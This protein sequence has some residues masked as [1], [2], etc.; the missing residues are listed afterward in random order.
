VTVGYPFL[1]SVRQWQVNVNL[2]KVRL[3]VFAD[4]SLR[5]RMI[6][7]SFGDSE[8]LKQEALRIH[9]RR[10]IMEGKHGEHAMRRLLALVKHGYPERFCT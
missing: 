7:M 6:T 4:S 1:L 9:W 2:A 10:E 3:N 5:E 8:K